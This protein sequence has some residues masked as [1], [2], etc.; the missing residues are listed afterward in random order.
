MHC[1]GHLKLPGESQS[2][3]DS[4][5]FSPLVIIYLLSKNSP[6]VIGGETSGKCF[7]SLFFFFFEIRGHSSAAPHLHV[8]CPGMIKW[9]TAEMLYSHE[10]C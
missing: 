5:Y 2:W 3:M 4:C 8:M 1:D 6:D 7:V 9:I 10:D